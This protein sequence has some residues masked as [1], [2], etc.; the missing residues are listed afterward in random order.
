[1]VIVILNITIAIIMDGYTAMCE[2]RKEM[3]KSVFKDLVDYSVFSQACSTLHVTTVFLLTAPSLSY[4]MYWG[5]LRRIY[6]L[7]GI[8]PQ[9]FQKRLNRTSK[10]KVCSNSTHTSRD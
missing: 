3:E 1:M 6:Y 9:D 8:L 4:Q 5:F 10:L 7:R 2:S